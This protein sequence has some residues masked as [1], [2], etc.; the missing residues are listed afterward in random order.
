TDFDV[1]DENNLQR[2]VL[3][4]V[5][6]IGKP[7]ATI[8]EEKVKALNPQILVTGYHTKLT[9]ENAMEIMANYDVIVDCTD[10]FAARYLINDS[11]V[12]SNKPLVYGA[13]SQF[14]GQVSL[15]N[16]KN[17][18]E[19]VGPNYRDLYPKPTSSTQLQNC[20]EGGVL[21]VLPGIIGSMQALE[22]IKVITGIGETLSGRLFLFDA[23]NFASR[24]ITIKHN[25]D[26][27]VNGEHQIA[28]ELKDYE[29]ICKSD[30][31][32]Y[33]S[34]ELTLQQL[35]NW[36]QNG[37]AYQLIDVREEEENH[38]LNIGGEVIPL[39]L[40]AANM[41][42]IDRTSKVVFYC[43][44]GNRSAQAIKILEEKYGFNNLYNLKG[45]I[46]AYLNI[47][48]TEGNKK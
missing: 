15:F 6:D 30:V 48:G 25:P 24:T 27:T 34:K 16:Y 37:E 17:N 4:T 35:A 26:N 21:G 31:L 8:A 33:S 32:G 22:A 44:S 12:I 3:F 14:E 2:Q 11:C 19:E 18:K 45:G 41:E 39:A 36:Q 20:A 23:L 1:V 10:N 43:N 13:I 9:S 38:T 42:K 28:K 29:H 5:E 7:K 40:I 46:T 47:K